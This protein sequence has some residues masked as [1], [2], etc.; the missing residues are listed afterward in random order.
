M[1][2]YKLYFA[3]FQGITGHIY[4]KNWAKRFSGVDKMFTPFFTGV[5]NYKTFSKRQLFELSS[6]NFGNTKVIPQINSKSSTEILQFAQFCN[7][8]GFDELNWNLGCP[9]PRVAKRGRGSGLLAKPLEV[10]NILN[11]VFAEI[12]INF[13][14]KCRIGYT[15][16]NDIFELIPIFNKYSLSE[17][18]VHPRTGN[19]MYKG[20]VDLSVFKQV[21]DLYKGNLVYNGDIL[22]ISDI[23]KIQKLA[24]S[25]DTFMIGRGLLS[26]PFLAMQINNIEFA[27]PTE[28][29]KSFIDD[30]L[31]DYIKQINND[32]VVVNILKELWKY[33]SSSFGDGNSVFN[34][35]KRTQNL[36]E[37]QTAVRRVFNEFEF[38]VIAA[39]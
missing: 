24:P 11:E 23:Y 27:N 39:R 18:I 28:T 6:T 9:F 29:L 10:D 26:N 16:K 3:P 14:I 22:K 31:F 21:A 19:Q 33:L 20:D 35:I 5:S 34:I 25:V 2:N 37:Y 32:G 12:K 13:S 4:R 38:V 36:D 17:L 1:Q 15:D 8:L 7:D 30:L